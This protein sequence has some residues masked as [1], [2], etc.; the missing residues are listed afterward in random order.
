MHLPPWLFE[1]DDPLVSEWV[2]RSM[3]YWDLEQQA[4]K[5]SD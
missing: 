2:I 5:R 4:V 1:T 3:A